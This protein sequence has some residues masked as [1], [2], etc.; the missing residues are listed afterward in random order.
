M[1]LKRPKANFNEGKTLSKFISLILP[2]KA[3]TN[4]DKRGKKNA[5]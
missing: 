5:K 3:P 1:G 2:L 4:S